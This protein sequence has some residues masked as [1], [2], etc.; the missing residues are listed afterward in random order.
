MIVSFVCLEVLVR[1]HPG[2]FKMI[3]IKIT[4]IHHNKTNKNNKKSMHA[5]VEN[6]STQN[7]N[8]KTH[9]EITTIIHPVNSSSSNYKNTKNNKQPLKLLVRVTTAKVKSCCDAGGKICKNLFNTNI[10]I[11]IVRFFWFIMVFLVVVSRALNRMNLCIA[12]HTP[13]SLFHLFG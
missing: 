6:T 5:K 8:S 1:V 4:T 3:A 7:N 9:I 10:F 12:M 11:V 13:L 2:R